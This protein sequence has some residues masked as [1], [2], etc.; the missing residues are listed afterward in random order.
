MPVDVP[1]H[2]DD[3]HSGDVDHEA[4]VR[5]DAAIAKENLVTRLRAGSPTSIALV[6]LGA[7]LAPGPGAGHRLAEKAEADGSAVGADKAPVDEDVAPVVSILR[8]VI[9]AR[10]D[11][12]VS[13]VFC[14]VA[15]PGILKRLV[16][17]SVAGLLM[18]ADFP[19]GGGYDLVPVNHRSAARF[20]D[21][22]PHPTGL[23]RHHSPSH[24]ST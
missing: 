22:R 23:P 10:D 1:L 11:I 17:E 13:G 15:I 2:G 7:E 20:L 18:V 21:N 4:G 3:G 6:V 24:T 16:K 19:D 8:T 9:E 14:P 12:E 5:D